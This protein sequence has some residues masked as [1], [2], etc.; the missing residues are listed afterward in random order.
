VASVRW[1]PIVP[2]IVAIGDYNNK[3]CL[4]NI[5]KNS[6]VRVMSGH[7]DRVSSLAWNE[8]I[9]SRFYIFPLVFPFFV[10]LGKFSLSVAQQ[11]KY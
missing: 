7:T 4:W 10:Q 9:L 6:L 8:Y 3:V 5:E 11:N 2:E 1:S